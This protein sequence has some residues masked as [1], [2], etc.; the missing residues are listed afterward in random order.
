MRYAGWNFEKTLLVRETANIARSGELLDVCLAVESDR[1]A[2]LANDV[3]VVLKKDW[4]VLDREIP[5]QVHRIERH[6]AT[7]TF[8]VACNIDLPAGGTQRIGVF[9][10]NPQAPRPDYQGNLDITG[11]GLAHTID[12][13]FYTVTTDAKSGQLKTI[14]AK[15]D[16]QGTTN[17]HRLDVPGSVQPGNIVVFAADD[18]S[19]GILPMSATPGLPAPTDTG[20]MPVPHLQQAASAADWQQPQIVEEA[21]GP[22]FFR[23]TRKG[24]LVPPGSDPKRDWPELEITYKFFAELPCILVHS[25]LTFPQDAGVF[26]VCNDVVSLSRA[27][28][29]HYTF[30]PV[31]PSLPLTDVEEMGHIVVDAVHGA[32]LPPGLAF[33]D[34]L[35]HHLAWHAFINIHLLKERAITG[36]QL[37]S[38]GGATYRPGTYVI[39]DEKSVQWC[40]API[41]VQ[42][43]NRRE[44]VIRV[45]AGTVFEEAN[46]LCFSNWDQQWGQRIDALGK[47]LNNPPA[48]TVHPV[49]LGDA[50]PEPFEPLPVGRRADAYLR[51]GVR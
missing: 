9:Y 34:F 51:A 32:D 1:A 29:S 46:T 47:R 24:R 20:K 33:S 12:T 44:N 39:R 8:R 17:L 37:A 27:M 2:N 16:D 42:A 10:D 50:P 19:M 14:T 49:Y 21:R 11:N 15:T 31:S 45:P 48:V 4:N 22:V 3:R 13:P 28:F 23:Q 7:T 30:R 43:R 5:S 25:R 6:G 41:Y 38:S 18:R 40:R 36:I 35:P 26:A